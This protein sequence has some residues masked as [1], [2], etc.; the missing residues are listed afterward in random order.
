MKDGF[1]VDHKETKAKGSHDA[2]SLIFINRRFIK[3]SVWERK[4]LIDNRSLPFDLNLI[5]INCG[6]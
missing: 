2:V 1:I 5:F 6:K 4:T 3:Q